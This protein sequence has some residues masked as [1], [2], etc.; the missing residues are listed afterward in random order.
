MFRNEC[1]IEHDIQRADSKICFFL[2]LLAAFK[3]QVR[4]NFTIRCSRFS[5]PILSVLFSFQLSTFIEE[6]PPFQPCELRACPIHD[7]LVRLE[8]TLHKMADTLGIGEMTG[9]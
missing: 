1:S 8:P 4:R 3:T 2:D 9:H 7:Y 6:H 5:K